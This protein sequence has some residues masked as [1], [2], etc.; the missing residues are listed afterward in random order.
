MKLRLGT[1]D[2]KSDVLSLYR[3]CA[4]RTG[5]CWT[6]DY[7]NEE[8][9]DVDIQNQWLYIA[10]QDGEIVGAASLMP[11]DDIETIGLPFDE[12][13]RVCVLTRLCVSPVLQGHGNGS[14]LL[15]LA[16]QQALANGARAVHLLCDLDNVK[17]RAMYLRAGYVE[18]GR[19]TLYG[20]EYFAYERILV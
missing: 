20:S 7:P 9:L 3:A 11:T 1:I 14:A 12:T 18:K 2:D 17:A 6:N 13:Q 4:D 19:P 8:F 16:E 15:A 5:T 10:E